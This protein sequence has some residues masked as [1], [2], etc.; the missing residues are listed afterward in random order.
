MLLSVLCGK[1]IVWLVKC[2]LEFSEEC[3]LVKT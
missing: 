1:K 3:R 2:A